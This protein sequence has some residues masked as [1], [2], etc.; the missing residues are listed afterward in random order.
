M[1]KCIVRRLYGVHALVLNIGCARCSF[2]QVVIPKA[3]LGFMPT[4]SI[5]C[6]VY[7]SEDPEKVK[8]AIEKIFP[9]AVIEEDDDGFFGTT[10]S[11]DTFSHRI[12]KQKILDATRS[13]MT[14]GKKGSDR[15]V[16]HLN[17]QVAFMGKVSFAEPKAILGTIKV[18]IEEDDIL[19]LIDKVAPETVDGEEVLR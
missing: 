10:Q 5:V 12:R 1:D 8:S 3:R 15:T 4:V 2:G 18:T 16:F 9:D 13:V 11:L 14:R 19:A 7:P 6:P 17:K